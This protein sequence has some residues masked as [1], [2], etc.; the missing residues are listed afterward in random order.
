M[1]LEVLAKLTTK[2]VLEIL[3]LEILNKEL[4]LIEM[5]TERPHGLS[6]G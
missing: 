1:S 6:T 3:I 2:E 4:L 5:I